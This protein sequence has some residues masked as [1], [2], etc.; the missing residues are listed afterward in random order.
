MEILLIIIIAVALAGSE[1][2]IEKKITK[3]DPW[4]KRFFSKWTKK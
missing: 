4:I 3:K 2:I 1:P